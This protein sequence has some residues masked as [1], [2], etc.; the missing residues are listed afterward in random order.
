MSTLIDLSSI[1]WRYWHISESGGQSS[2]ARKTMG[3]VGGL[4]QIFNDVKICIDSP[5]YERNE[6]YPEYKAGREKPI[7]AVEEL[8]RCIAELKQDGWPILSCQGWEADDVIASYCAQN[9]G[10]HDVIGQDKD[11]LQIADICLYNPFVERSESASERLGVAEDQVVDYLALIGDSADNIKGVKGVG[12]VTAQ[13]MLAEFLTL[14]GILNAVESYPEKFKPSTAANLK[15]GIDDLLMARRLIKL[16]TELEI[17]VEQVERKTPEYKE[18]DEPKDAEFQIEEKPEP[19]PNEPP[20]QV[21]ITTTHEQLSYKQS[22][23]PIGHDQCWLTSRIIC[24]SGLYQDKFRNAESIYSVAMM[25]RALGLDINTALQNMH[26]IRGKIGM[27]AKMI[28]AL[29]LSSGKAEYFECTEAT[30]E[31]A[32]W[33]T[34]RIGGKA[35]RSKTFT[36]EM[37]EK[38]DLLRPGKNGAKTQWHKMPE[39]M[40]TWRS[41]TALGRIV[42]PDVMLGL[43]TPDEL[44]GE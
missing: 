5:P 23:E 9:E 36:I 14:D 17:K 12:K 32:T 15:A 22:L 28:V 21:A 19:E 43:Y 40:L 11:L 44:G 42:Y 39:T 6:I 16:N 18:K 3:M 25:G 20:R 4:F 29:I 33:I 1:Y 8:K 31:K 37:A 34:K 10:S 30:P 7:G 2:A 41:A 35:E 38:M 27:D 24:N 13:K 26:M